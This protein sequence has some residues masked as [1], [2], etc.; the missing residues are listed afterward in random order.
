M[1]KMNCH[2]CNK[3]LA[4]PL[5]FRKHLIYVHQIPEESALGLEEY[6]KSSCEKRF[7]CHHTNCKFK[8]YRMMSLREHI[9]HMHHTGNFYH[10][11][12]KMCGY[13]TRILGNFHIHMAQKHSVNFKKE[14]RFF[15]RRMEKGVYYKCNLC[16]FNGKDEKDII[17]HWKKT[18]PKYWNWSPLWMESYQP[19][20]PIMT[21][22]VS[23]TETQ[24][25]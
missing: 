3:K 19:K 5:S 1:K 24:K 6:F 16:D 2:I 23:V 13:R 7:V 15:R 9:N 20:N 10:H 11:V 12:C 4:D 25:Y 22:C 17:S 21:G 8:S 18:H 14:S